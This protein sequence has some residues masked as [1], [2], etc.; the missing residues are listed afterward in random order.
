M[1]IKTSVA[2]VEGKQPSKMVDEV[3]RLIKA[4]NLIK[5]EDKVLIKPNYVSAKHPSTGITTD[6]RIV[7]S[8][9]KFV[10]NSG[11]SEFIHMRRSWIDWKIGLIRIPKMQKCS[12][13]YC[14]RKLEIMRG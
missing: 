7:E 1:M 3:L 4:E 2:I 10:K 9:I 8:L 11:V 14:E 6:S 13:K 5:P 12:C